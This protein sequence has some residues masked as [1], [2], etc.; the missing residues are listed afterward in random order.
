MNRTEALAPDPAPWPSLR[1]L[2]LAVLAVAVLAVAWRIVQASAGVDLF[3]DDAYYYTV[4]AR[5][6]VQSGRITFDG[7]A[8][9]N[10]FHPLLF[11]IEAAGFALLGTDASP[12]SQYLTLMIA[13]AAVFVLTLGACLWI[14]QARTSSKA[15]LVVRT[16][17]FLTV[18]ILLI[19]RFSKPF[20]G[21]MESILVL[22]L[23]LLVGWLA[24]RRRYAVAGMAALL[25]VMARLDMLPY[26]VFPLGLVVAWRERSELR[27]AARSVL[28][29]CA[30]AGAGTLG[31]MAW[32][33]SYFGHPAPIHGVLK[34]CFPRINFQWHQVFGR[35]YG[36]M[37]L[38]FALLAATVAIGLLIRRRPEGNDTS[39]NDT[40]GNEARGAGLTAALLCLIQLAAFMLFQ[41]W[42]K[43]IPV[44]YLGP[45]LLT[46]SFALGVG[47]LSRLGPRGLRAMTMAAVLLAVTINAAS[48]ARAWH[49]GAPLWA[50][51]SVVP[52]CTAG[53]AGELVEFIKR[54]P[55]EELFA[56]TDCGKLAFWSGR[57][58][59]N[60][61]GLVNDF[62]YQKALRDGRLA[63]YLAG[64]NVK[65]LIFPA[66]DRPL[67]QG[68]YE[69]MYEHRVAPA[70]YSGDYESA[71]FYV[72]SYQHM[73]YSDRV[74]L[75]LSAEVWRSATLRDGRALCKTVVF[76]LPRAR[77]DAMRVEKTAQRR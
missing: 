16:A 21:G 62:A 77:R 68:A 11:W 32:H 24:W 31:L 54:Q 48:Y 7:S 75:S 13:V 18:C 41:K 6:F 19:P 64:R 17:L 51:P 56:A 67:A 52:A 46:G 33:W 29:L 20:L 10:G 26:V 38:W 1:L 23:L 43:P 65:Y 40:S 60:L 15:D 61:D 72:Y 45:A 8:L 12:Q 34:S 35:G 3:S 69:P 66:W 49:R 58:V 4:T 22:P 59:V 36:G 5:N 73:T 53:D 57:R 39:G 42:S 50:A 37:T 44:W 14:A 55:P 74:P 30:A 27:R 2:S 63:E 25:L 70:L 28:S 76:D 71:E 47:L 9:T